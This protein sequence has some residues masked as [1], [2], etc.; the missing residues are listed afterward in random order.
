MSLTDN[1]SIPNPTSTDQLWDVLIVG[2]GFAGL[3][4]L[5]RLRSLGF[6]VKVL[7]AG[8][9]LGGV[10][11]WNCYPGARVDT[12]GPIY[13]FSRDDLWRDWEFSELYPNW[14]EVRDYFHYVDAK[15]DLSK[16]IQFNTFVTNASYNEAETEWTVTTEVGETLRTRI[17]L[18]CTGF[19]SKP[20]VPEIPGMEDFAGDCHHTARWPQGGLA[21]DG[22]RVAVIGTGASGVQVTQEAARVAKSVTV[23]QRTPMLALPMRQQKLDAEGQAL[24]KATFPERFAM[25]EKTFG[26]FDIE[27]LGRSAWPAPFVRSGRCGSRR[28]PFDGRIAERTRRG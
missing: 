9:S 8:A 20:Y 4:Q 24:L 10:W 2:G 14:E 5:E 15:L 11:Y 6:S 25:R 19:G 3:Y 28:F 7:E 16:D 23:F 12:N 17:L 21:L 27:F 18:L 26:G 22:K 1:R 13:Q